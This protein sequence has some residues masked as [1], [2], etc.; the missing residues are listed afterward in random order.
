MCLSVSVTYNT[1]PEVGCFRQG[2][3]HIFFHLYV[4]LVT[5]QVILYHFRNNPFSFCMDYP[6]RTTFTESFSMSWHRMY[7]RNLIMLSHD[8][9]E[10]SCFGAWV[11]TSG[12]VLRR[13][14]QFTLSLVKAT[15]F[16]Y[17]CIVHGAVIIWSNLLYSWISVHSQRVSNAELYTQTT[18]FVIITYLKT[19]ITTVIAINCF[20]ND[21]E[22][23]PSEQRVSTQW[24][25]NLFWW[26]KSFFLHP[27]LTWTSLLAE[28]FRDQEV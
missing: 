14:G 21:S 26:F 2:R 10:A 16:T 20:Y 3:W 8:T 19:F 9:H 18:V 23:L 13:Q 28:L 4:I 1:H 17:S 7:A 6:Q 5:V 24:S 15:L 22:S 27:F 12:E 11:V 25:R